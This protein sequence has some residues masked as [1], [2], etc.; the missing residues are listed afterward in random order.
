MNYQKKGKGYVF[1]RAI[2][3]HRVPQHIQNLV[4]RDYCQRQNIQYLLS[5]TEYAMPSSFLILED[6]VRQVKLNQ[7]NF[8]SIIL[9]S[10]FQLPFDQIYRVGILEQLLGAGVHVYTAAE[11]E[12]I[13]SNDDI[14]RLN[15]IFLVEQL[16]PSYKIV[17]SGN[18]TGN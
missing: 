4:I 2:N 15:D 18:G 7:A 16:A 12:R 10:L 13:C 14:L 5:A 11:G 8:D 17:G 1:S 6:L 3:Q 9:Y